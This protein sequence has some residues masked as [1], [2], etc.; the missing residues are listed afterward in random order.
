MKA[1][2]DILFRTLIILYFWHTFWK[3]TAVL[4]FR[5]SWNFGKEISLRWVFYWYSAT[6]CFYKAVM[7]FSAEPLYPSIV[8]I[9]KTKNL[10]N[11]LMSSSDLITKSTSLFFNCKEMHS[12]EKNGILCCY[13]RGML[14]ICFLS[15]QNLEDCAPKVNPWM[16]SM[17][18]EALEKWSTNL[19]WSSSSSSSETS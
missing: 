7:T 10:I 12:Q 5:S 1:M 11:I 4:I 19:I 2:Y 9:V 15:I 16:S 13:L 3:M 18:K 17:W 8:R 6:D 14:L